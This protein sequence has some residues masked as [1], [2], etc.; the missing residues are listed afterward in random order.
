M[1]KIKIGDRVRFLKEKGEGIVNRIEKNILYVESSDGFEIPMA[2]KDCVIVTEDASFIPAY[3]TPSQKREQ[4]KENYNLDKNR[5]IIYNNNNSPTLIKGKDKLNVSIAFVPKDIK[6]L[7]Q[8]TFDTY[9]INDSNR[10]ISF[11]YAYRDYYDNNIWHFIYEGKVNPNEKFFIEEVDHSE[12]GDMSKICLQLF[13]Y[14]EDNSFTILPSYCVEQHLDAK[15]FMKL[16]CFQENPFFKNSSMILPIIIDNKPNNKQDISTFEI[17]VLSPISKPK[18]NQ[19]QKETKNNNSDR[20]VIDLHIEKLVDNTLGLQPIDILKKQMDT[21]NNIMKDNKDNIGK[22]IVFIHGKGNGI[23][24]NKIEKE[25]KHS[26]RNAEYRDASFLE[27]GYGATL[28]IIHS[29][30]FDNN[31]KWK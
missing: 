29:S 19:E 12:I 4:E 14:D 8:T 10:S 21:F 18:V 5:T 26:Y 28:V 6:T 9:I 11:L 24:R 23:L 13:S 20:L 2:E 15:K 25:L 3:R 30:N 17:G 27:Y 31:K 1:R 7:S 16:G 22:H